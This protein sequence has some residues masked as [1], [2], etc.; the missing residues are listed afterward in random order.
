MTNHNWG[1]KVL[2]PVIQ[3]VK[4]FENDVEDAQIKH[5]PS[6]KDKDL[7]LTLFISKKATFMILVNASPK[8][9]PVQQSLNGTLQT[10]T[11][12][13]WG[14]TQNIKAELKNG[15]ITVKQIKP[16]EVLIFKVV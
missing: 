5:I 2:A 8:A 13:P 10:G 7:I 11:L 4:A 16:W 15:Q 12:K 9:Q 1:A 6:D 3:E 14:N